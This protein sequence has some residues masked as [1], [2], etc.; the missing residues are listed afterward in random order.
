MPEKLIRDPVHDVIAFRLEDATDSL[1]YQLVNADE[2]QRLRRIRQLGM[3]HFAYP[4]ADHSRY[5]HSLG[6]ME[7]A[8]RILNRLSG[9][10][11]IDPDQRKACLVAALLHDLGHGPFSH[12]FE[13]ISHIH[14]ERLTQRVILDHDSEIHRILIQHDKLMPERV[15]NMLNPSR[16][17]T[18]FN[19][20][21]SSQLDAD[22]LDYLLRDNYMTGSRYG[23]FDLTWLLQAL[24][25]DPATHRLAVTAKGVSAV[26]AYLQ[27]RYH[28]YRNV[29]FHK[30]VRGAEGMVKLALNRAKR[31]AVQD[32]LDGLP[33]ESPVAKALLGQRLSSEEFRDLDDISIWH[34]FKIWTRSADSTLASL[35]RGLLFRKLYK[36]ID[37]THRCDGPGARA[38]FAAAADH[39]RAHGGDAD[40]DLFYD[41]PADTPYKSYPSDAADHS[42][43]IQIVAPDGAVKHFTELSPMT[44]ALDRQLMFRR[45][46]VSAQWRDAAGN[47]V[48]AVLQDRQKSGI[49]KT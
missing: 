19:D 7:T 6:V 9:S 2:F 37:L 46:H 17:P 38:A 30:V 33:R 27:A 29:Y 16:K 15:L 1:L 40:Y 20:I 41:E 22:R 47:V 5:S 21:L 31:L 8:R 49:T 32:R 28:M 34:C 26:E 36:T 45:I 10:M 3:A 13:R 25:V 23:D 18:F 39:I 11:V 4:G 12:V 43:E 24:T 44:Q 35:C 14:H 48:D 42:S